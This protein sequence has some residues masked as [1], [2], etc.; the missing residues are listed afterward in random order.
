MVKYCGNC[1]AKITGEGKFCSSCGQD[2]NGMDK[3]DDELEEITEKSE[4]PDSLTNYQMEK[5][6]TKKKE[7]DIPDEEA[8]DIDF[9]VEDNKSELQSMPEVKHEDDIRNEIYEQRER[10]ER[11]DAEEEYDN[12]EEMIKPVR[13]NPQATP[14]NHKRSA[15]F[16]VFAVIFVVLALGAGLAFYRAYKEKEGDGLPKKIGNIDAY[17]VGTP[18]FGYISLPTTWQQYKTQEGG[19]TLQYSDGTG[20]ITTLYAVSMQQLAPHS[21]S[22]SIVEEMK[23]MGAE[24]VNLEPSK[25]YQYDGFYITGYY[26]SVN[27]YISAWIFDGNDSKTHYISIE[28]PGKLTKDNSYSEIVNSFRTNK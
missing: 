14:K 4:A 24:D 2:I 5:P 25:V 8:G 27:V 17:R 12:I 6:K 23:K 15:F 18:D 28:G 19:A 1:G 13:R 16:K 21:W 3:K 11:Q 9:S 22:N 7:L 26:R 20:W 10:K